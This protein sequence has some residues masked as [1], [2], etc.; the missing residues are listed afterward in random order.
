MKGVPQDSLTAPTHDH[1]C[2]VS[3]VIVGFFD[4]HS[5][6]NLIVVHS[7]AQDSSNFCNQN[8]YF[9]KLEKFTRIALIFP[10]S[11]KL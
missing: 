6:I 1:F 10:K 4:W 8:F 9:S 7:Q 2:H 5:Y 11:S 3:L